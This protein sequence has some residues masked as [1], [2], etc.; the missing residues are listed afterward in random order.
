M[1]IR[2]QIHAP[3]TI[4]SNKFPYTGNDN[5]NPFI[6]NLLQSKK[7]SNDIVRGPQPDNSN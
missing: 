6:N 7:D 4:N 3:P 2:E 1:I 5:S